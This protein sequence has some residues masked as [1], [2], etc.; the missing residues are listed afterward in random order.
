MH[1][2]S[3]LG[4][5]PFFSDFYPL[6]QALSHPRDLTHHSFLVYTDQRRLRVISIDMTPI[7]E[8]SPL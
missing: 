4:H 7:T 1:A 2:L 5:C 8:T 3:L 6:H